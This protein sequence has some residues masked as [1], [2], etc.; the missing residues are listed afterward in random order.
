MKLASIVKYS[1]DNDE[2]LAFKWHEDDLRLGSQLI[3]GEGQ[4]AIF[5]KGGEA[6]DIFYPGT[7]TLSTGNLPLIDKL[8]NLPFDNETPFSAEIWFIN[9]LVK[10]DLLWG[11]PTP[12]QVL[13]KSLGIPV[14]LRSFGKWGIRIIEPRPFLLQL[15]GN[16]HLVEAEKVY[17]YLIGQII[18]LL[19][20]R[21]AETIS[22][23]LPVLEINTQLNEISEQL[24]ADIETYLLEYGIELV[25]FNIESINIPDDELDSIKEVMGK[26]FEAEQLSKARLT[27]N[28]AT[29]KSFEVLSDAANNQAD[30]GMAGLMQAGLGLGAGLPIGQKVG[31]AMTISETN[32]TDT[33]GVVE[34]VKKLRSLLDL[35]LISQEEYDLKRIKILD[36]L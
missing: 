1:P 18:Q 15:V 24:T 28:F 4:Q 26:V 14:S 36:E 35:E 33:D 17:R 32:E 9:T 21:L 23:G 20:D 7:H 13:D 16:Q 6:L 27:G 22:Q 12:I 11:T 5:V 2:S 30:S 3:V 29:I 25:N 8:I 19:K 34:K 31:E 10:R